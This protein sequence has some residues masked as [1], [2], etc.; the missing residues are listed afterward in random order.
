MEVYDPRYCADLGDGYLVK[1]ADEVEARSY[2]HLCDVVFR[3]SADAPIRNLNAMQVI[4]WTD[5]HPNTSHS[6]IAVVVDA[7]DTVVAGAVL[8]RQT[9]DYAGNLLQVGRPELVVCHP[10]YRNRGFIRHIFTLLHAKSHARG[11]ALQAITGIPY[12]YRQFG[13]A[14][15]IDYDQQRVVPFAKIL[16][17]TEGMQSIHLRIAEADTYA[18]FIAL[19]DT[20]R[21]SRGL[22][23]TTPI[24]R[25]YFTHLRTQSQAVSAFDPFFLIDEEDQSVLG[26]VLIYRG[27]YDANVCVLGAGL[28]KDVGWHSMLTPLIQQLER[29]RF[30]IRITNPAI[31]ALTGVSFILDSKHPIY[32]QLSYGFVYTETPTYAWYIR[33]PDYQ[34]LFDAMNPILEARVAHSSMQGYSGELIVSCYGQGFTMQWHNGRLMSTRNTRPPLMG[35][36]AHACLPN[37]TM[38][39][40][41]F[42][43]RSLSQIQEWH[44]EAWANH[45]ADQLLG[46]LFPTQSS[47]FLWLN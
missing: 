34:R 14:Y 39:M 43:R 19:Y 47:W 5:A 24:E 25:S 38:L 31:D 32:A 26:Y 7:H 17:H 3:R 41:V 44:H 22:L 23:C 8:L 2:G 28:R 18:A 16:K 27:N 35:E 12:Y 10:E 33:V 36:G 1:W 6:D 42:G 21:L 37:D 9:M 13:Y 40:M 15:A 45:P 4:D 46:I 30:N 29:Y 11:D 20:D